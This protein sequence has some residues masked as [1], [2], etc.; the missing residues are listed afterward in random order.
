MWS[1]G[2]GSSSSSSSSSSDGGGA[3]PYRDFNLVYQVKAI[4]VDQ[5][6]SAANMRWATDLAAQVGPY[7]SGAYVN[8]IDP[9][10]R[11]WP[12]QY[13]AHNYARL[14]AVKNRVDP[15]NFFRFKQSIGAPTSN[16][17]VAVGVVVMAEEEEA[18]AETE[19]EA[20]TSS[21]C[22]QS[23]LVAQMYAF[24]RGQNAMDAAA[25]SLLYTPNGT[26]FIP[27]G[28]GQP[29]S[30]GR[31]AIRM[32]FAAYFETLQSIHE[33]VEGPMIANGNMGAFAKTITTV[34]KKDSGVGV[35]PLMRTSHV[36]NWF[37]FDCSASPPLISS[38]SAMFNKTS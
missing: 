29:T 9:L 11:D 20:A 34:A 10:L 27:A 14:V 3:F 5:D 4:W 37:A 8:Y 7:T 15:G 16:G 23:V 33:V 17:A 2:H 36:V 26:N 31:A 38:F 6:E 22:E 21:S 13:Y 19:R 1:T 28:S 24:Q 35:A 12:A 25:L 18:R 32:S 30:V